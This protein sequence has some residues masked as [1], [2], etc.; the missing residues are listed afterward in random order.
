MARLFAVFACATLCISVCGLVEPVRGRAAPCIFLRCLAVFFHGRF[1]FTLRAVLPFVIRHM[2]TSLIF[3]PVSMG[4]PR[5]NAR[6][7]MRF[8]FGA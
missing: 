4:C 7:G 2:L 6:A 3:L 1:A 5:R 8:A